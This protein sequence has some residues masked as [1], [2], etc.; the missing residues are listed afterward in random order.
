MSEKRIRSYEVKCLIELLGALVNQEEIPK[1]VRQ[2]NWG[3]LYKLADYHSVANVV[4]YGVLGTDDKEL[5]TWKKKFEERFHQ[6]VFGEERFASAI[7]EVLSVLEQFKIHSIVLHEY[8]MRHFYPQGDMRATK[9]VRILVEK[10]KEDVLAKAMEYLDF[11]KQESRIEGETRYYKIPGILIIFQSALSFTNKKI[12]KYFSLPVKNYR[13]ETDYRYIHG[14]DPEEF[15]VYVIACAAESYAR[16][17]LEIQSI[18]DIWF[19]YISVYKNLDWTV[20]NKEMTYLDLGNFPEYIIKLAAFWF[21]GMLF[22]EEDT[23]FDSMERYILTKGVQCRKESERLLPLV[24]EVADFYKKDLKRK[25]RQQR[26]EWIFPQMEYMS[27]MFPFLQKHSWLLLFC[28]IVRI[29]RMSGQQIKLWIQQKNQDIRRICKRIFGVRIERIQNWY[30]PKLNALGCW[31]SHK[32][33]VI[34]IWGKSKIQNIEKKRIDF[35]RKG[36]G[37]IN[38]RDK[39]KKLRK[40]K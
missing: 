5:L 17:N 35:K 3:S 14:F 1:W 28:W 8:R 26:M 31:F 15:Y 6:A 23:L 37:I 11:E 18:L 25:R 20:I 2:P 21:G 33:A 40:K 12:K 34:T 38:L 9:F 39:I 30:K 7:P 24:K 13:R 4:Y 16:G 10:G 19:Y 29:L 22:P 27:T 36:I 32:R